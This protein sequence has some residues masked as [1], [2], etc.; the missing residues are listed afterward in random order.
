MS[1]PAVAVIVLNWNNLRDLQP[2]LESL[3]GI[4]YEAATI[5]V[6]DNG[7]SD[8][9]AAF[10]REHF[11]EV[12]LIALPENLGFSGGNNVGIRWAMAEGYPYVWLL[13]NDTLVDPGVL[14]PLVAMAED[15]SVG[16]VGSKIYYADR[17]HLLWFAGG[18][19]DFDYGRIWHRGIREEDLGQYD[20]PADVDYLTGCSLLVGTA[21]LEQVG[22]LDEAFHA[23][24]E[25]CDWCRR[26][27]EADWRLVYVPGSKVWHKISASSGGH[28]TLK[29][30]SRRL[31]GQVQ[32]LR[33]HAPWWRW[34]WIVGAFFVDGLRVLLNR[35]T[36]F[37]PQESPSDRDPEKFS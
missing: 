36:H 1:S 19:I 18:M 35:R 28:F 23:Y 11:P 37:T 14:E 32:F 24:G 17:P 25:D 30:I 4:T 6:V 33:R 9:S 5:V 29:K 31:R 16:A 8:G 20:H 2:C 10:V 21:V 13:N 27:R 7:S 22:L 26:I 3:R 15:P 12:H 34:P